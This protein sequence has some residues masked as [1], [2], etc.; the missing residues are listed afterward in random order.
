MPLS[1]QTKGENTSNFNNIS[2]V[3]IV[4]FFYCGIELDIENH[5]I[6]LVL[7]STNNDRQR[8]FLMDLTV[9]INVVLHMLLADAQHLHNTR[10]DQACAAA[11]F[12]LCRNRMTEYCKSVSCISN[13]YRLQARNVALKSLQLAPSCR[14]AAAVGF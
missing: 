11:A 1:F 12:C 6:S 2:K 10:E 9:S 14:T 5:G 7:V 4:F 8:L 13:T 3:F